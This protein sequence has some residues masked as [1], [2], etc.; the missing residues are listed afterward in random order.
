MKITEQT[1]INFDEATVVISGDTMTIS[2]SSMWYGGQSASVSLPLDFVN[3][4]ASVLN[5]RNIMID[6][7][8][9]GLKMLMPKQWADRKEKKNDNLK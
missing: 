5:G 2:Q 8:S 7:Q 1:V 3:K 9:N 4:L 6:A